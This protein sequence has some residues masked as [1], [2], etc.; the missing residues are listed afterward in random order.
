MWAK[1]PVVA[2]LVTAAVAAGGAAASSEPSSSRAP[3]TVEVRAVSDGAATTTPESIPVED[4]SVQAGMGSAS[5]PA[6][7]A[8][9]RV[10]TPTRASCEHPDELDVL[11]IGN[12]YTNMH[13]LPA[14]LSELGTDAGIRIHAEKL[15]TGGQ[16]FD[17]HLDRKQTKAAIEDGDW[18]VVVLQSHSLD[19]LRNP[20][21]FMRS[22][23]RLAELVKA[24][25][26]TPV[27]FQTWPRKAGHNLYNYF[28][29]CGGAPDVMFERV[30]KAYEA[31]SEATGAEVVEVG[32][33]WVELGSCAPDLDPYANDAAHPGRIGAYLTANVFFA[34][35]THVSPVGNVGPELKLSSNVAERVQA[36]AESVV[37]P[38]CAA[39]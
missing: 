4:P 5:T 18:D 7:A 27:L 20:E 22:G 13:D 3:G 11:F 17:Y 10:D 28:K 38:P 33:A 30:A 23:K 19:P 2:V 39:I 32:R 34:A 35:L 26:A 31:L 15:A 25:G 16:N 36:V 12:S 6:D 8:T 1:T 14:L 9:D 37:H 21:G 24:A 29:P